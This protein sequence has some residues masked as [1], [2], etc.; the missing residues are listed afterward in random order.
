MWYNPR[1]HGWGLT[2][3]QQ[4]CH[5]IEI[6]VCTSAPYSNAKGRHGTLLPKRLMP[7]RV[8]WER[9]QW[10]LQPLCPGHPSLENPLPASHTKPRAVSGPR[11]SCQHRQ[12]RPRLPSVAPP[13]GGP[14]SLG[15]DTLPGNPPASKR[16]PTTTHP[17]AQRGP[18][19]TLL[20]AGVLGGRWD[21]SAS[22]AAFQHCHKTVL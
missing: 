1:A 7:S 18:G 9:W 19:M 3:G 22:A 11:P 5:E 4:A 8:P 6:I 21:A 14:A 2:R 16:S 15:A 17:W 13:K 20:L 12:P 10:L